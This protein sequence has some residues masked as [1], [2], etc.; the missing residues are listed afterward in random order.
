MTTSPPKKNALS[1]LF[2]RALDANVLGP[3][4]PLYR[5]D[6][7]RDIRR[8]QKLR[9]ELGRGWQ[10]LL[11]RPLYRKWLY[12]R[13]LQLRCEQ[14]HLRRL[15]MESAM[16]EFARQNPQFRDTEDEDFWRDL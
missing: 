1:H 12:S 8:F 11:P 2:Y 4:G 9:Q 3:C 6:T 15:R 13:L 5:R 7:E 10:R 16:I 14:V